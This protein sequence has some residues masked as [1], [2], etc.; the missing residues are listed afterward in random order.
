MMKQEL[1]EK[2]SAALI[3]QSA[4]EPRESVRPYERD[5]GG[6]PAVSQ[7]RKRASSWRG[8]RKLRNCA[9][10]ID[11]RTLLHFHFLYVTFKVIPMN[12]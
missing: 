12:A 7:C 3:K 10:F 11:S 1:R 5:F 6:T 8:F 2:T 4:A 9:S